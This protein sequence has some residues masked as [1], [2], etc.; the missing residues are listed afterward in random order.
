MRSGPLLREGAFLFLGG[1]GRNY[2]VAIGMVLLP[3]AHGVLV[4]TF[5]TASV[6]ALLCAAGAFAGPS[7]V[8]PETPVS[9]E[10]PRPLHGCMDAADTT[11]L[12][13]RIEQVLVRSAAFVVK[14]DSTRSLSLVLDSIDG[15]CR[16]QA[17]LL[18]QGTR[19]SAARILVDGE[20]LVRSFALTQALDELSQGWLSSRTSRLQIQSQPSGVGV[21][22]HDTLLGITP[23]MLERL[24]PEPMIYRL[25]AHGWETLQD[26]VQLWAGVPV[27]RE[28]QLVRSRQ[29]RDSLQ[30]E[31]AKVRKDS[32]W[33][34]AINHTTNTLPELYRRL[35]EVLPAKGG[36]ITILPFQELGDLP[37]G[38]S[39][40]ALAAEVGTLRLLPGKGWTLSDTAAVHAA[41]GRDGFGIQGSTPDSAVGELGK[42]LGGSVIM[43]GMVNVKEGQQLLSVRMVSA[44]NGELLAA[45]MAELESAP[46]EDS[47]RNLYGRRT[48]MSD[49]LWRSA[50]VPGWGQYG[51]GARWHAA[52]AAGAT[53]VTG[54]ATAWSWLD[55]GAKNDRLDLYLKHDLSTVRA[56]EKFADWRDR[57]EQVRADRNDAAIRSTILTGV[58]GTVWLANL[59]D[60]GILGY[61]R[62]HEIRSRQYHWVPTIRVAPTE[63]RMDWT[64]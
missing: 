1:C 64:Y 33:A 61:Q 18:N 42:K 43:V 44:L 52:A 35:F 36:K 54:A 13:R 47:Y 29:W 53:V 2:L 20:P 19:T 38:Y 23:L 27:K 51:L 14:P 26:S 60:A 50:V 40:G 22:L 37:A 16:L 41:F 6:L 15:N 10:L 62:S 46:L 49:A 5:L 17:T 57:A 21:Y 24:K 8:L 4:R 63:M 25:A 58:L 30:H 39:P 12:R 32:L 48:E 56:G 31:V 7:W 59:V 34:I 45:G 28:L 3:Y 11:S 9:L 55:Y